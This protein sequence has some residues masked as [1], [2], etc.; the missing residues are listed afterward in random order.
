MTKIIAMYLPQYHETEDNNKWWGKG[1]TDWISVKN[2]EKLFVGHRQ[3]REPLGDRYYDLSDVDN[4][5][6]QVDLAKKYGVYG[7]GIYH[8][9]FSSQKQTLTKP[10]ELLLENKD[11]NMPFF[12]HG[13]TIRGC[14]LGANISTIQMLGRQ[15]PIQILKKAVMTVFLQN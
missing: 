12:W 4:I 9:W 14:E 15:R 8:Y 11:I 5:R 10:A 3:P 13:I 1:F 7:F 2:S 6:W